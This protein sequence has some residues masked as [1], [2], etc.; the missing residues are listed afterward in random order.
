MAADDTVLFELDE[1]V[2][3]VTLNRPKRHNAVTWDMAEKL[4][5]LFRELQTN[6]EVKVIVLTGA[7]GRAFCAGGDI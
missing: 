7:G 1:G 3:I 5:E 6:D 4:V 2:G